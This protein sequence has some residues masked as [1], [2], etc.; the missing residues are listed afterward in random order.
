MSPPPAKLLQLGGTAVPRIAPGY[1]AI[2]AAL[3]LTA[4][5]DV[6]SKRDRTHA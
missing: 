5:R 2:S 3:W 4:L 6:L 1:L